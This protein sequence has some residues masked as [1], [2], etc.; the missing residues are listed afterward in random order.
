M[1]RAM[2]LYTYVV[3][4]NGSSYVVQD[5]RSN[6]RGFVNWAH[7]PKD[8][9][10]GI[11]PKLQ[12]ELIDKAYRGDFEALANRKNVWQKTIE[13]DNG[14]LTVHAIQTEA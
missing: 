4:F 7:I 8:A 2:P 3:S 14:L 6:Y 1:D 11:T 9:L 10:P 12:R 13:L 5:R